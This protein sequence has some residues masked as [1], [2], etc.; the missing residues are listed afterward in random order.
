MSFPSGPLN[1]LT[2]VTGIRVGHHTMAADDH[3]TGCTVVVGPEGGLAAGVDVR[4]GGPG[5]RETDLLDPSAS[6]DRISA[7]TLTGGSAFGLASA[8][9]VTDGLADRGVGLA[10]GNDPGLVVPIVPAAV[11]FDL[12]RGGRFRA[13]PGEAAGRAALD[14]AFASDPTDAVDGC[15]GAGTG[16]VVA[17]LKGGV[18]SASAVLPDGTVVAVLVVVNAVGS[19]VDPR[20][21]RLLAARHLL[22]VDAPGLGRPDPAELPELWKF[23][24]ARHPSLNPPPGAVV[25]STTIGVVA[26]NAALTKSQCRKMAAISHDGLA[27]ALDPLHTLFDGDTMFGVATW[28]RPAPELLGLHEILCAASD[29]ATRAVARAVLSATGVRTGTGYWPSYADLAPSA[30]RLPS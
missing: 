26:T 22:D 25:Q 7:I 3:L 30:W 1:S 8:V 2:D 12:G 21:G 16:A 6:V 23:A 11:L 20:D 13:T 17:N 19:P 4:G 18:G 15:V 28:E 27:R 10:V 24:A 29:V 14:A 5:T 9:G